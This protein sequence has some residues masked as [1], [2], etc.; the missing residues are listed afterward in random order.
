MNQKKSIV[1]VL[2]PFCLTAL[3]LGLVVWPWMRRV[4]LVDPWFAAM[5][6][7]NAAIWL[8]VLWWSLHHL[9]FQLSALFKLPAQR[10]RVVSEDIQFVLLYLTCDD[11]QADSCLSCL[12]QEYPRDR[13][14]LLICDDSEKEESKQGII[15]FE[16]EN[17]KFFEKE[18]PRAE[19][20]PREAKRKGFK[21][22]NLNHAFATQLRKDEE[23]VVIVDADQLLPKDYLGQLATVLAQQDENVAF[24]QASHAAR[25]E[26]TPTGSAKH[27]RFQEVLGAEISLFYERD[28]SFRESFGFLPFLG[29]GGA[30][31][32]SS[33]EKVGGFPEVV[34][35]DYA[36][37]LAVSSTDQ[38]GVFVET[39]RSYESFPENFGN[40]LIRFRKFSGGSAEL[41]RKHAMKFLRGT[42]SRAEKLDFVMLLLWYPLMPVIVFNGFLSA[43]VCHRWWSLGI[44]ALH[45]VLPY[46]FLAMFLLPFPILASVTQKISASVRYWFW[47]VAVYGACLPLGAARFLF[48]LFKDPVFEPTPKGRAGS[49]GTRGTGL[50]MVSL[51]MGTLALSLYWWS[52]FTPVLA[53]Y[54]VAYVISPMFGWVDHRGARGR[55]A[56]VTIC[57]PGLLLIGAL[58]TMW[59]WGRSSRAL[60]VPTL[61]LPVED[62]WQ[63]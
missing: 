7:L 3:V 16:K 11:F 24:V 38:R 17:H 12:N 1:L 15:R 49:V 2:L 23:W 56:R 62:M 55:F 30:V 29:H 21:A 36:F 37:S 18:D 52:P 4:D 39:I 47:S 35:E 44:P 43:Y 59:Y 58:W 10:V 25:N 33:W 20:I 51:G 19:V 60:E 45:P 5:A 13:F 6:R 61:R 26:E 22:G 50:G 46:L 34:S 53:A 8:I 40:F 27:H 14:R 42:A 57:I 28:L 32:R 31:R 63:G 48:H 41:L 54:G 9:T